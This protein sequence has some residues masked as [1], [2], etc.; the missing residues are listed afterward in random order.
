MRTMEAGTGR[1][2]RCVVLIESDDGQRIAYEVG[3]TPSHPLVTTLYGEGAIE[4]RGAFL[5]GARW[6]APMPDTTY[7]PPPELPTTRRD[8]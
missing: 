5:G 4:V 6:D 8:R 3:N 2:V 7:R 1:A